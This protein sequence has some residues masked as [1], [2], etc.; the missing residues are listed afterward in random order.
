MTRLKSALLATALI[1]N[2]I[3][4][5]A[6]CRITGSGADRQ[7]T[8][9]GKP[10]IILGGE[11]GNSSASS[12]ADVERI[13]P[14]LNR[15]GLNTVLVPAYWDLM[16]PEEGKF[17]F[18]LIDAAI[19]T[20][21]QNNLH[22]VFLWFGAWKNSMSCYAPE[23]FKV[24]CKRFPRAH[25]A[26]GKPLEIASAFAENV[27]QADARAFE[28]LVA[29]IAKTDTEHTVVMLQIE[30]EI[31]MLEN[32]RDYSADA[33]KLYDAQ[34]PERLTTYL[35]KNAK[36]LH[37]DLLDRWTASGKK[38]R[39]TWAELFG[40]DA[41]GEEIFM[42]YHYALYVGRLADIARKFTEMPLYVNAA[43]NSRGRRPGQYPAAGP[44]AHL[45]DVWRCGAPAVDFISPDIYD[46]GFTGWV[47][48]YAVCGNALF[49]PE[50]R[51][52]EDNGA[53]AF[54]AIG[55]HK[56]LGVSPFS[57][58]NGNENGMLRKAYAKL[59]ALTPFLSTHT[60]RRG[61]LFEN[62]EQEQTWEMDGLRIVARHFFTLPWDPR[63]TDGSTWP[64]AGAMFIRIAPK[65]YILAG[66][67]VV[68]TFESLSEIKADAK[69]AAK[70]GEDGFA[71]A[72]SDEKGA[73]SKWT[74]KSRIGIASV[75][76]VEIQA[77]GT[78][79]R[80]RRLNGD[81]D[82]QGRHVRIGVDDFQVLHI[83]LYEYK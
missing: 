5:S 81:E 62:K 40:A 67:G 14:K 68:L 20:A 51:L 74:A 34:V 78:F 36:T 58:E 1:F 35:K 25:T 16:E 70:L 82:H 45:I 30:N 38:T 71:M 32:A 69:Q 11:L 12:V 18:T 49:I 50:M 33:Q 10:F 47:D 75:D 44:L 8:L 77:D 7:L 48:R 57:I 55:Q 65:E 42:A 39:G 4:A 31:G 60:D 28:S 83:K 72:G 23:W 52:C 37:P 73:A 41:Y 64:Q 76:E 56:A 17:D 24:D 53:Q 43:M 80:L 66:T 63:A 27:F 79:K 22:V 46:S 6:Q 54:Y 26:E 9:D 3:N 13:F 29:H 2:A 19:G 21:R 15:M 61:M 59:E